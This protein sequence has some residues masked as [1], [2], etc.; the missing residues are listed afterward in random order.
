MKNIQKIAITGGKGGTGKSTFSILLAQKYISAGKKVVLADLDVDCP[1]DHLLLQ[2]QLQKVA[3][4]VYHN[5][6]QINAKKCTQCGLCVKICAKNALFQIPKKP[7]SL[8]DANCIS[9]FLCK[10]A[11]P[12]HAISQKKEQVGEVF[13]NKT[14]ENFVLVSGQSKVGLKESVIVVNKTKKIAETYA[15]DNKFDVMLLDL[16]AGTHCNVIAGLQNIDFAYAVTEPTP[17]GANTLA[18]ILQ[19]LKTLNIKQKIVLNKA[20]L[21]NRNLI[22]DRLKKFSKKPLAIDVEIPYLEEIEKK[23]INGN[24][25]KLPIFLI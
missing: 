19:V 14:G 17:L 12:A 16:P 25:N 22:I 24:L 15:K 2:I 20:D 10:E 23:Y 18:L 6:P 8:I 11:C 5:F 3:E 13:I 1:N 9:C 7:P 4:T 21:G